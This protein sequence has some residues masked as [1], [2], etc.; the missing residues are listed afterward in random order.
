MKELVKRLLYKISPRWTTA[1]QSARARAHSHRVVAGWGCGPLTRKLV[2]RF[3]SSVQ[4]GPFEGLTLTPMTHAEQIGPYLLGV[5][6]SELDEAWETV[7]R[8]AY[9][10][11]IDIGA[12][13]GYYAVGLARRYPRASVVAFDT[14]WWARKA[15]REM[16]WANATRNVEIKGYCSPGWLAGNTREGAFIISDC[17]GYEAVLFGPSTIPRLGSATLIIE[18]HDSFVPG[19]SERLG[20]AFAETHSVRVYDTE[21]SRR[22]AA[23]PLDFLSATERQLALLE[24]RPPA[25]QRWL[26]CLPKS[27]PNQALR[28]TGGAVSR[29]S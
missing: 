5:Y 26:L 7:F 18:A 6:E 25:L 2:A 29:N 12:K 1:L 27:G 3:G 19:V 10:Q 8:G 21:T 20:A 17:E 23:R 4:E 13:F 24:V 22:D 11:I 28:L 9:T 15:V 16:A 14:D